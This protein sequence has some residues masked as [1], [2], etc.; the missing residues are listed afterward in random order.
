[1][2]GPVELVIIAPAELSAYV[3]GEFGP[4]ER[5]DVAACI[6]EDER[7]ICLI[8]SWQWQLGLLHAAFAE[9]VDE[10]VPA[11]LKGAAGLE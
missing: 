6:R 1:M 4:D 10:P 3:D 9:V 5:R 2:A 7:A 11:R 8:R